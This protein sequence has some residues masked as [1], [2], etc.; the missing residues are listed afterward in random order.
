MAVFSVLLNILQKN[1]AN[2][3]FLFLYAIFLAVIYFFLVT[4]I[5]L[6][7]YT[8]GSNSTSKLYILT[9]SR[10]FRMVIRGDKF[11]NTLVTYIPLYT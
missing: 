4:K 5:K 9:G 10:Y 2:E 1:F 8:C 11:F 3:L 6:I 7:Y